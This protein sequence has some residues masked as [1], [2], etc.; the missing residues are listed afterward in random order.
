MKSS[1]IIFTAKKIAII[2]LMS[3]LLIV[4]KFTLS[5]IPNV[6]V[7]TTLVVCFSFVFKGIMARIDWPRD[8]GAGFGQK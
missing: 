8:V 2:A 4:G 5:F 1:R 6:E 7:V 3:S